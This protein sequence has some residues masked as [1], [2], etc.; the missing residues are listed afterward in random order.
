MT[1]QIIKIVKENNVETQEV[2]CEGDSLYLIKKEFYKIINQKPD[3]NNINYQLIKKPS[4]KKPIPKP[5]IKSEKE[6][7]KEQKEREKKLKEKIKQNKKKVK[8]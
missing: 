2:V 8:K 5:I 6:I 3:D 4:N 7:K 1:F